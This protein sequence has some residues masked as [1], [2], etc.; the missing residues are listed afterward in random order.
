MNII[1]DKFK[2]I[3]FYLETR[4][5]QDAVDML[6]QL[7]HVREYKVGVEFMIDYIDDESIKLPDEINNE[8]ISLK[9]LLN[10]DR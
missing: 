10:I 1:D 6:V 7:L 2:R 5:H 3:L 4:L 9:K 8:L